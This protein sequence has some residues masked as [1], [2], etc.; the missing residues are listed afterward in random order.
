VRP[1]PA[2][3]AAAGAAAG[4]A[5]GPRWPIV[6]LAVALTLPLVA[7][8]WMLRGAVAAV[9]IA[10][11][12]VGSARLHATQRTALGPDLGHALRGRAT[13]LEA[14]RRRAFG[15]RVA[16]VRLRGEA[17]LLRASRGVR[18]PRAEVGAVLAVRGGLEALP[19]RE[20]SY[21]ARGV[22]AQVRAWAI[23]AT[24][25]R[26]GG[27]AGVIDTIR[28]RAAAALRS[29][30]PP[31][32]AALLR[33]MVLGD[34]SALPAT[35][36]ADMQATGLTHLVAASGANV[37]LLAALALAIC[38][39]LG[40]DRRGRLILVLGLT[41]LYVPLA[42]GGPS[43]QRAGI[44]GAAGTVAA[45]AGRPADRWYALLLAVVVTLLLQPR[46]AE[47]VGWQLSFA[48]VAGIAVLAAPARAGLT[49]RRVPGPL[50][51]GV[52]VTVAATLGT[53]PLIALHFGQASPVTL[54][55]NVLAA[56]L[57]APVM[58]LGYV[59]GAL[60]QVSSAAAAPLTALAGL[61]VSVLLALAHAAAR[62][63][64]ASWTAPPLLVALGCGGGAIAIAARRARRPALALTAALCLA[65][66]TV[67]HAGASG[68]APP[69]GARVTFLDVGQGDATLLQ[70]HEH[71][72]LVDTGPPDGGIVTRLRHAG[73]RRLD[74]LVITHAQD[75][76]DGGGAAVLAALPVGLVVD[77]RDGVREPSGL[78]LAARARARG[79]GDVSGEQGQRLRAGGIALEVLWPPPREPGAPPAGG[80]DPNQRAI[81]ALATLGG[82]RVLLTADAESDVLAPLGLDAVDVLKVSHHGSADAGLPALLQ[83]LRPRLAGIEVGAHNTFGHPVP[84][85]VAALRAAGARVVRTDRDGSVAVEPAG[86][87]LRVTPHV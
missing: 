72:I 9:V 45:L 80:E 65:T 24:G 41:A 5:L 10:G 11:A 27:P 56:P 53:A 36:R 64:G 15:V 43:I 55:A 6:A 70:D 47:Q 69:T 34:D 28:S 79:V 12:F 25:A 32:Q 35:V 68:L 61:P 8:T 29:G 17:V 16:V 44:M 51:E 46:A 4:L 23:A 26:R 3:T 2:H 75:D 49:R 84:A 67:A 59:A 22:H 7:R 38:A 66:W 40:I 30:L 1:R 63:P 13:L 57:V 48:A 60:G 77:G 86:G 19:A 50:A 81:V 58:W 54:P 39:A 85:T 52:A 14:P 78:A 74:A 31:P 37:L 82:M 33:G 42:G 87:A 20:S 83:T 18:W 73:V 21:A 62:W 71:A 76:H